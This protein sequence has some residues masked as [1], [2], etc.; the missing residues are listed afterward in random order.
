MLDLNQN[1]IVSL[2][3]SVR[4]VLMG[5]ELGDLSE[6]HVADVNKRVVL[7]DGILDLLGAELV[8]G[9]KHRGVFVQPYYLVDGQ[10]FEQDGFSHGEI[11]I[12]SQVDQLEHAAKTHK[13][14]HW[15]LICLCIQ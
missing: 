2:D 6:G 7:E 4:Y 5:K 11:L 12:P 1:P 9:M 3:F 15:H 13:A 14:C 10:H 8:I